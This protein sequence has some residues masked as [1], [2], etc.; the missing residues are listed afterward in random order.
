MVEVSEICKRFYETYGTPPC[1][2]ALGLPR[3]I[4]N[5]CFIDFLEIELLEAILYEKKLRLV[6]DH[7]TFRERRC[8]ISK[9]HKVRIKVKLYGKRICL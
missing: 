4:A 8:R 1:E 7:G 5:F 2:H 6:I 9:A 3:L